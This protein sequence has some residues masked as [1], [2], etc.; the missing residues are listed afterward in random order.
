MITALL[1]LEVDNRKR[2]SEN[3]HAALAQDSYPM[4]LFLPVPPLVFLL[5]VTK[6][7]YLHSLK[8]SVTILDDGNILIIIMC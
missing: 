5:L 1:S 7:I 4:P 3:N 6:I 8:P 2:G